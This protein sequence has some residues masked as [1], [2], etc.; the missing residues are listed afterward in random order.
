MLN[1]N[2]LKNRWDKRYRSNSDDISAVEVLSENC[3]LLPE[4]GDALDLA[5]GRGGNALLLAGAGLSSH[6][7]DISTVALEQLKVDANNQK[8]DITT[9]WQDVEKMPPEKN[10]FDVITVSYFLKRSLCADLMAALRPGGLLFYQTFCREKI[11]SKGPSNPDFLLQR[12]ELLALFNPLILLFYREDN[13]SGDLE[14]GRRN[15][16]AFVGQKKK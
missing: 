5:C 11:I 9:R 15:T 10:S 16:A 2:E 7:W 12:N 14:S 6:A 8:L 1:S 13:K 4:D 3:H